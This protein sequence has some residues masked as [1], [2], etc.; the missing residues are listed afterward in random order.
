[1]KLMRNSQI[2]LLALFG[3]LFASTTW[4]ADAC[5]TGEEVLPDYTM[6]TPQPTYG[7]N[8]ISLNQLVGGSE[9]FSAITSNV[10]DV[11]PRETTYIRRLVPAS[12][13]PS[14]SPTPC[15]SYTWVPTTSSKPSDAD[16][17]A[18]VMVKASNPNTLNSAKFYLRPSN[19]ADP[20]SGGQ[21]SQV[22]AT[23]PASANAAI[24][25]QLATSD[26][27]PQDWAANGVRYVVLNIGAGSGHYDDFYAETTYPGQLSFTFAFEMVAPTSGVKKSFGFSY[28]VKYYPRLKFMN[29]PVNVTADSCSSALK[30]NLVDGNG[31]T[32]K[33]SDVDAGFFPSDAVTLAMTLSPAVAYLDP[34]CLYN[35]SKMTIAKTYPTSEPT[36]GRWNE[37]ISDSYVQFYIKSSKAQAAQQVSLSYTPGQSFSVSAVQVEGIL[38]GAPDQVVFEN[39]PSSVDQG[40]CSSAIVV[41]VED[42]EGN[43]TAPSSNLTV[44]ITKTASTTLYSDPG[45]TSA[46]PNVTIPAGQKTATFY[47]KDNAA[48]NL[49]LGATSGALLD[50]KVSIRVLARDLVA[51]PATLEAAQNMARRLYLHLAGMPMNETKQIPDWNVDTTGTGPKYPQLK[52][53]TDKIMAGDV[54]QAAYLATR[55][56]GF[57][58]STL[59]NMITPLSDAGKNSLGTTGTITDLNDF[60]ATWIGIVRDD[61]NAQL[62]LTGNQIYVPKAY[63]PASAGACAASAVY[64]STQPYVD[65]MTAMYADPINNGLD[66]QLVPAPQCVYNNSKELAFSSDNPIIHPDAAGLLTTRQWGVAGLYMGTNRRAIR[67]MLDRFLCHDIT[68]VRDSGLAEWRIRRDVDHAPGGDPKIYHA[69]CRSCHTSLDSLGGAYA[70]YD[71]YPNPNQNVNPVGNLSDWRLFYV[72]AGGYGEDVTMPKMNKNS[73]VFPPGY[74]TGDDSWINF[75]TTNNWQPIFGWSSAVPTQANGVHALGMMIA[76]SEGFS[77]CMAKRVYQQVCTMGTPANVDVNFNGPDAGVI[78]DLSTYFQST[79]YNMRRLFQKAASL[80]SCLGTGAGGS[81]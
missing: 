61:L 56:P 70:F 72:N 57:Y 10:E 5:P 71:S 78:N 77:K 54:M 37:T 12:P 21:N 15:P 32:V 27:T 34:N 13:V 22:Y 1:M 17:V 43:D 76:N 14:G 28:P 11:S 48:E 33:L 75:L 47:L 74:V 25:A 20:R 51:P 40:K 7:S 49:H 79:N 58:N 4:G 8:S 53:Y 38:G 50:D 9:G 66:K 39:A 63:K 35:T 80:S 23:M 44:N 30:V 69:S 24:Q 64:K 52:L 73:S 42:E 19:T 60:T 26:K 65:A 67:Y 41:G 18:I 62:L 16:R 59:W 29:S 2:K 45:C 36:T 68:D 3:A 31:A 55:E 81:Q 6:P 46:V